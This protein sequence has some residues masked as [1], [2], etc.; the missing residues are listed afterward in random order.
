MDNFGSDAFWLPLPLWPVCWKIRI[1]P[2]G[3]ALRRGAPK[4]SRTPG[5]VGTCAVI[6][7]VIIRL[8]AA[9]R[10]GRG[11]SKRARPASSSGVRSG[12]SR[13]ESRT[14][15]HGP[16]P[17][18]SCSGMRWGAYPAAQLQRRRKMCRLEHVCSTQ[19]TFCGRTVGSP[20]RES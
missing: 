12:P 16:R 19:S 2:P 9:S 5:R 10:T 13:R 11:R 14:P 3:R 7:H 4:V 1:W 17:L 6:V 20:G 18:N 15:P 8:Q